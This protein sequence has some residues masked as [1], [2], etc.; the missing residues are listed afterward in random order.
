MPITLPPLSR[1]RFLSTA[2]A[3]GAGVVIAPWEAWAAPK[4]DPNR[5][6]LLSDTHLPG[7]KAQKHP[8]SGTMPW[9]NFEKAAD[10]ILFR[11]P[12]PG[13]TLV[14]GDCAYLTGQAGDYASIVA[15]VAPLRAGG[16]PVHFALGNHDHRANFWN[17]LPADAR[18]PA[19][20]DKHATILKLPRANIFMLDSL[21]TTDKVPGKIGE[22]QRDW[23]AKALD[24]LADKPAI[25]MSHHQ[26]D[27]R[28]KIDGLLDSK[29]TTELLLSRKHVKAWLFGHTHNWAHEERDGLHLVNLPPVAWVFNKAKPNGW[30]DLNLLAD[31]AS[32]ELR[33][34]DDDHP[35]DGHTLALKWR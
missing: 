27:S 13:N 35:Q 9:K 22:A 5:I 6:A 31:G 10:D 34:L 4:L 3:A 14:C 19:L 33:T 16:I 28:Q 1:R 21:D 12:R 25:I 8:Q 26:P 17:A 29:E 24:Q 7:D 30:V 2:L 18:D 15:A 20:A 23:L 11:T 32:F